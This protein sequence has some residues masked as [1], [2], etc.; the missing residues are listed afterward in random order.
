MLSAPPSTSSVCQ[1][2]QCDWLTGSGAATNSVP[3]AA[4]GC[5]RGSLV[6]EA[7][8]SAQ[9]DDDHAVAARAI[10]AIRAI[11]AQRCGSPVCMKE[12]HNRSPLI[13]AILQAP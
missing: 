5:R 11:R 13:E 4:V 3:G 1:P 6:I 10:K 7:G 2:Y 12:N 9:A 8:V